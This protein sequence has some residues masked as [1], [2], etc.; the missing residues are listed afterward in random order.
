MSIINVYY[1]MSIIVT[2]IPNEWYHRNII[3]I[4]PTRRDLTME[5][6]P[7]LSSYWTFSKAHCPEPSK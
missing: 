2:F 6:A 3:C 5:S 4:N 7:N 1:K